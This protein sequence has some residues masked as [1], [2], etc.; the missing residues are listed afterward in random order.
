[1]K[2][3][4]YALLCMA[5]VLS[6]ACPAFASEVPLTPEAAGAILRERGIYQGDASGD[7]MLDKGLSRAELAV[8]LTRLHGEGE[9]DPSIYTWA[10]YFTDV[11]GWARPYVGYCVANLLVSGYDSTRYGPSDPVTPAMACTVVFRC[12][13]YEH[14]EGSD[15][16]YRTAC[17]YA[18]SLGLISQSTAQA[19]IITRGEMAVLIC[20]TL[21]QNET[22]PA[23]PEPVSQGDGITVGPDGTITSKVITQPAWSR[24]D[25]S[26]Q[27]N[28]EIFTGCY[29]REWYNALRQSIVDRDTIVPGNNEDYLNPRYLY[30]HT[31]VPYTSKEAFN[32]FSDLI[33]R[34]CCSNARTV[35]QLLL[36][37]PVPV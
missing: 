16:T 35:R 5:L 14:G 19:P 32:A 26:R 4:L 15:W 10:C 31:L 21:K 23:N 33:L 36:R 29:T 22:T 30:A 7:L 18:V 25:F 8:L 27:A 28:P 37:F 20:R 34:P 1:M 11:P 9:V 12:G 13:S 24:E 17:D 3:T 6:L 2:K